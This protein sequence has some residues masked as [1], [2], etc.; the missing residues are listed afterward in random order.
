MKPKEEF[1][2]LEEPKEKFNKAVKI[3]KSICRIKNYAM[4]FSGGKD[5][6][7]MD[8][9]CIEAGVKVPKVYNNTTI[10]PPGTIEFCRRHGCKIVTPKKTFLQ[11]VE[12]KGFPT[13]FRRF[14]CKELKEKYISDYL[15]T[16]VRKDES[17]KRG[18]RYDCMEDTYIYTKKVRTIRFMP[19][20]YFTDDDVEWCIKNYKIEVPSLYYDDIGQFDVKRRLGCIGCPLQGDRGKSDFKQYPKLLEQ[21]IKR[22]VKFHINHGRTAHDAYLNI[23]YNIFYSNGKYEKYLQTYQGLFETDPKVIIKET[24]GIVLD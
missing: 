20:L 19:L 15:L 13:M 9:I 12:E 1:I 4:A 22:G 6:C 17:K 3:I 21:I 11:L 10:D 8:A 18:K 23:V 16:G 7:L 14:C 5:S 24:F 2:N